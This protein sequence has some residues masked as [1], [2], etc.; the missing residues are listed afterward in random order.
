MPTSAYNCFSLFFTYIFQIRGHSFIFLP[1]EKKVPKADWIEI[2]P[3]PTGFTI[4]DEKFKLVPSKSFHTGQKKRSRKNE[5]LFY[6]STSGTQS[7]RQKIVG[8][9]SEALLKNVHFFLTRFENHETDTFIV[10]S[11]L[12]FDPA[13]LVI[14]EAIFNR[15]DIILLSKRELLTPR[16]LS[17]ALTNQK[18]IR[19][20]FLTP[21]LVKT[22]RK[23]RNA[24]LKYV[25]IGGEEPVPHSELI[26]VFGNIEFYN[27]YG[28][29]EVSIWACLTEIRPK[30]TKIPLLRSKEEKST[31]LLFGITNIVVRNGKIVI[32]FENS[33]QTEVDG[34]FISQ[35]FETGDFGCVN[36]QVSLILTQFCCF[37]FRPKVFIDLVASKVA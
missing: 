20:L 26:E 17:D 18:N 9:S 27:I 25:L 12:W 31:Q 10:L 23:V 37:F 21:T 19:R 3:D 4:L 30:E 22:L 15:S 34:E 6:A 14:F 8:V 7:A 24:N 1:V 5:I 36:S 13:V 2:F 16:L 28:L 32:Q 29:T 35:E 33:R 11:P